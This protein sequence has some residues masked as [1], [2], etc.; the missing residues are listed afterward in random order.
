MLQ[1]LLIAFNLSSLPVRLQDAIIYS[2]IKI[3]YGVHLK[4]PHSGMSVRND[5]TVA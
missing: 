2:G 4:Q 5:A 3:D 1:W